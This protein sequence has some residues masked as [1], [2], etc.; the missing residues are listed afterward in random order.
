MA[1]DLSLPNLSL[2]A[3]RV[4]TA[5][6]HE[7]PVT[8]TMKAGERVCR[9]PVVTRLDKGWKYDPRIRDRSPL[10]IFFAD[11]DPIRLDDCV[12]IVLGT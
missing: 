11:G 8:I 6:A 10:T 12:E 4:N 9:Q 2:L 5:I 3:H 1:Q 7:V